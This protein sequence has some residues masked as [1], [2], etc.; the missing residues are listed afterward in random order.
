MSEQNEQKLS[1]KMKKSMI[2]WWQGDIRA[3]SLVVLDLMDII[4]QE[5]DAEIAQR[6]STQ[7][8]ELSEEEIKLIDAYADH[9]QHITAIQLLIEQIYNFAKTLPTSQKRRSY[10]CMMQERIGE[11]LGE[12]FMRIINEARL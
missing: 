6:L 5:R 2:D 9:R 3:K 10:A 8:R 11:T 7:S 4:Q 12:T 1:E